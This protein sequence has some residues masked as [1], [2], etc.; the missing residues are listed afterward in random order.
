MSSGP[1]NHLQREKSPY[2]LQHA[3]N[4]VDWHPW[5]EEAFN[6][7]RR[8]DRPVFLSVGY[9]TCHWCHVMAHESFEDEEAA[10]LLNGAFVCVKVDREE[11]PDIDA[12][13]MKAC[14]MMTGGGGWPLTVVMTPER[15]PFFAATYIPKESRLGRTGLMELVPR[16][17]ELW[18][19]RRAEVE[20]AAA[21]SVSLIRRAESERGNVPGPETLERGF[22]ELREAFDETFGGFG[23]AP[24]F[25]VPHQLV[26]LIRY[27]RRTGEKEAL[28]MACRTLDAMRRGGIFDHLG[29]GFH[30]YSTDRRWLV[31]HFEKMLYD[32]ALLAMAFLEACEATGDA[33]YAGTARETLD[34]ALRD[35]RSPDGGFFAAED[36]DSEGEEGLFYLWRME[37]IRRLLGTEDADFAAKLFSISEK[38]NFA[39]PMTGG[40]TG[41]NI[42]HLSRSP[43]ETA[44]RLGIS[45]RELAERRET[46]RLR[47]LEA[48]GR[49]VRPHRDDK[50]LADW[51]GLMIAALA[52]AARVLAEPLYLERARAAADFIFERMRTPEGRLV[53]RWRDGEAAVPGTLDDYAFLIQGLIEL[54]GAGFSAGD[55]KRAL[56]LQTVLDDHF[57]DPEG[58][59]FLTP[60]DG[61]TLLFRPKESHD[62]ALPSGNAVAM[63]NLIRLARLT[64]DPRREAEAETLAN[65]FA[66]SIRRIPTA[67][68]QWL[69]A[70]ELLAAPSCEVVISG[71]PCE[72]DT[73]RMID[74]VRSLYLPNLSVLFRPEGEEGEEIA[75]IAPFTKGMGAINGRAAAWVCTGF[76]CSRPVTDPTELAALLSQSGKG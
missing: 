22:A 57:R 31:P 14:Q 8:E 60:D 26:F 75:Q 40:K 5:G 23:D 64:G 37:E 20:K 33:A 41:A 38:G 25:P 30:R 13:Y 44:A 21:E 68:A 2:L 74:A 72:E 49:R 73:R 16:L 24:K 12:I 17:S 1:P 69:C 18:R 15:R 67:H 11:R 4:P 7:A 34:Y 9:S 66:G 27:A 71:R 53:H 3:L 42:L 46:V 65:A 32:Q 59:Y 39:D 19:T 6:R 28:R 10:A 47:L 29:Y 58:G 56:S 76:S 61:E 63:A 70:L 62:G 55:L 50:I 48:R 54:Y 52:R 43:E 36:A 45:E 35:L 51:N